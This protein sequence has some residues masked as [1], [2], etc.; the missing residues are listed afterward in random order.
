MAKKK[1]IRRD[2]TLWKGQTYSQNI[3]FTYETT[4]QPIP[5]DGITAKAEIRPSYNSKVLIAT[6]ICT[7][8]ANE[9]KVNLALDAETTAAIAP[10][11]YAWDL[12]MTDQSG[13]VAYYIEGKFIVDGRVTE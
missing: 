10:G 5:L 6:L 7:V 12:K 11:I 13:Q 3:W 9:G 8:Y 1:P 2:L 4:K